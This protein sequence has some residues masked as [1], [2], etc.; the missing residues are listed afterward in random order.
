MTRRGFLAAALTAP[1]VFVSAQ[2][3][4]MM[5]IV[6]AHQHLWDLSRFKLPWIK[7]GEPPLGSSHTP[8]EYA[9]V[10]KGFNVVKAVYMEVGMA[11]EDRPR[12]VDYIVE[13]CRSGATPT[14]AAVVAGDPASPDFANAIA[15]FKGGKYVK[16]IRHMLHVEGVKASDGLKPEF[17]KG[18]RLLGEQGLSFDLCIRPGEIAEIDRIVGECPGTRFILDHCGNPNRNFTPAETLAWKRGITALAARKNVVCK[19]SGIVVNGFVKGEWTADDLAPFV[20]AVLDVFGPDRVMF[21]SDWPVCT[22]TATF[23]Q[24]VNALR[25]IVGNRAE[26][27]QRKL[28]HDNAV[29]FYGLA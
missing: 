2:D 24:W 14:C 20:N 3:A 28:F 25:Q 8:N 27:E 16:G 23:A 7:S 22:L 9:E 19:V 11:V 18:L 6:D 29:K 10:T 1:S 26:G 4:A 21:A 12:E 17:L 13:L 5:P 15:P